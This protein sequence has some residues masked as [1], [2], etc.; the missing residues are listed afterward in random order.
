[1]SLLLTTPCCNPVLENKE[2]VVLIESAPNGQL[3]EIN[4]ILG[5]QLEV[6][7]ITN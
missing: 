7:G 4:A 6:E 1:M 2:E 5:S 3:D